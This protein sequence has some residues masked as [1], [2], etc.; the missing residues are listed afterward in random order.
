MLSVF[1]LLSF[2]ACGCNT[3]K[4]IEFNENFV[5]GYSDGI[6]NS[7]YEKLSYKVCYKEDMYGYNL[8]N[9]LNKNDFTFGDGLYVT[10]LTQLDSAPETIKNNEIYTSLLDTDK[11]FSYETSFSMPVTYFKGTEKQKDFTDT[12]K[13]QVYFC[14]HGMSFA[15]IYSFVTAT[16][17]VFNDLGEEKTVEQI[18][19]EFSVSYNK[20]HYTQTLSVPNSEPKVTKNDYDFK[21]LIDNTQLLFALRNF[22]VTKD[23]PRGIDVVS[24]NYLEHVNLGVYF[25]ENTTE[26]TDNLT[27]NGQEINEE[28]KLDKI[29][30]KVNSAKNAGQ[31][32]FVFLQNS[33]NNGKLINNSYVYKYV[34][35]LLAFTS[36]EI[37]G[38]LEYTLIE[39]DTII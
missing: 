28:I 15:P 38:S 6:L 20:T 13:T 7:Y 31:D 29:S 3:P 9:K 5:R 23:N 32:H 17:S 33:Q 36:Y 34:Q 21:C 27:F 2:G 22:E 14:T 30:Y 8:S 18:S 37:M 12:I 4:A 26:N 24:S 11:I 35:P 19:Y 10:N 39:I 25:L 16:Y 1:C